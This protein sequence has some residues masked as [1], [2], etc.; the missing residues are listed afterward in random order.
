M[1]WEGASAKVLPAGFLTPFCEHFQQ[2]LLG[3]KRE[4]LPD[5]L[6][7]KS[8]RAIWI[9]RA[10]RWQMGWLVD[11]LHWQTE[12]GIGR[13]HRL[14]GDQP[15]TCRHLRAERPHYHPH[16]QLEPLWHSETGSQNSWWGRTLRT[17][18][19]LFGSHS[20]SEAQTSFLHLGTCPA[21]RRGSRCSSCANWPLSLLPPSWHSPNN[22]RASLLL[23]C[24]Q[25][26]HMQ[27]Y[28]MIRLP[29]ST[30]VQLHS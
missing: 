15:P 10:E 19:A 21:C 14:L 18:E 1:F 5:S 4:R 2:E 11:F 23:I 9:A 16:R 17:R 12:T 8:V 25:A 28:N 26:A 7:S 13:N 29:I 30:W 27:V 3:G 22:S 24:H 6:V 20:L